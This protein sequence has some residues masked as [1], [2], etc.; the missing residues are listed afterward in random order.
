MR[1]WLSAATY[2][3]R[4]SDGSVHIVYYVRRVRSSVPSYDQNTAWAA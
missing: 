3:I 2:M 1:A 4:A